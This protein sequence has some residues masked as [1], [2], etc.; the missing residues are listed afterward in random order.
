MLTVC[1]PQ[2]HVLSKGACLHRNYSLIPLN[3]I[4]RNQ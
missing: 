4:L 3:R 1:T 2:C